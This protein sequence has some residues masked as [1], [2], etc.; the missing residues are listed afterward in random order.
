MLGASIVLL[1][2]FIAIE[3]RT[4]EP[5]IPL[6]IFKTTNLLSS[7]IVMALLGGSM[8]LNVVFP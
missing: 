3:K 7:N 1:G 5:L 2:A 8:D 4:K 6:G